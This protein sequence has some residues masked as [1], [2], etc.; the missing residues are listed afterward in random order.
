MWRHIGM[1]KEK[2]KN[3]VAMQLFVLHE[4]KQCNTDNR[5]NLALYNRIEKKGN[6]FAKL[7]TKVYRSPCGRKKMSLLQNYL[8]TNQTNANKNNYDSEVEGM[9]HDS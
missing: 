5:Q 4:D 8:R 9:K 6:I 1:E 3:L 2:K 7:Q